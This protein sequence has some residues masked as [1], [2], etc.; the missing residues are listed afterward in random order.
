MRLRRTEITAISE[1][2]KNPFMK[3]SS[4]ISVTSDQNSPAMLFLLL[5]PTFYHSARLDSLA[6]DDYEESDQP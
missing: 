1:P 5:Y 4:K 6:C 3:M 2:E